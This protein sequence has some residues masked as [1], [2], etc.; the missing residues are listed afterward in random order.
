MNIAESKALRKLGC[1]VKVKDLTESY[2]ILKVQVQ[3]T[4]STEDM[5]ARSCVSLAKNGSF[6]HYLQGSPVGSIPSLVEVN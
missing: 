6:V 4:W 1:F 5:D 3:T 2:I